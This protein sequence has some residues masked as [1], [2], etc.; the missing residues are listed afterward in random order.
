M[1]KYIHLNLKKYTHEQVAQL[2]EWAIEAWANL[3]D[4]R[5]PCP[6]TAAH[7]ALHAAACRVRDL[8]DTGHFSQDQIQDLTNRIADIQ[9]AIG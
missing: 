7:E 6:L 8:E 4:P 5:P 3:T 2:N 9:K 1:P